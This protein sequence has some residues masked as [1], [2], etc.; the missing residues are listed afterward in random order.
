LTPEETS[1]PIQPGTP[2]GKATALNSNKRCAAVTDVAAWLEEL[3]LAK[4]APF[5]S[6]NEVGLADFSELSEDDLKEIGLPLGASGSAIP[7]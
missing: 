1:P 5:F 6:E 3:G 4:Y 2:L 7:R